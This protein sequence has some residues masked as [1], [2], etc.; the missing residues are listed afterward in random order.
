MKRHGSRM[1]LLLAATLALAGAAAP[2]AWAKGPG[3][4]VVTPVADVKWSDAGMPGVTTAGVDG[5]MKKGASHFFLKYAAGFV[6]PMHHHSPDHHVVT[7]TGNLVLIMGDGKE[8]RLAPGSYFALKDKAP[9][10]ARCEGAQDCVMF[11]DAR[12]RWDVVPS[13]K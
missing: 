2:L 1:D 10:A 5:D 7:V 4:T 11:I 12:G 13:K 3:K 6:A 9:H 8:M